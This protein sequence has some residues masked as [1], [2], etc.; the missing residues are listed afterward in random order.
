M[1]LEQKRA[2]THRAAVEQTSDE[3]F[4]NTLHVR[5]DILDHI[6]WEPQMHMGATV[7]HV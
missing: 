7:G 3:Q 6:A 2:A 1:V 5:Q 4:P